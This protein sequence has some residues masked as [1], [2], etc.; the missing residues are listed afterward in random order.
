MCCDAPLRLCVQM[1]KK[2]QIDTENDKNPQNFHFSKF[3]RI[4][5]QFFD[6]LLELEKKV[7]RVNKEKVGCPVLFSEKFIA[8]S[9]MKMSQIDPEIDKN[10]K[11]LLFSK[12]LGTFFQIS[13]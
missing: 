12:I 13:D 3:L 5:C 1:N 6:G 7:F 4:F 8:F 10:S 9:K 11:L 2:Y